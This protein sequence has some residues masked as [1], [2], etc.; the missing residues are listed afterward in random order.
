MLYSV[1]SILFPTE[2]S[3]PQRQGH[4][5]VVRNNSKIMNKYLLDR[6]IEI[7]TALLLCFSPAGFA[8]SQTKVGPKPV[9]LFTAVVEEEKKDEDVD[10]KEGSH[11]NKPARH[12][13][14]E[15]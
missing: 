4:A 7:V 11:E 9:P 6:S 14:A 8:Y 15:N 1:V 10:P 2:D 12:V 13:V 5:L 3:D